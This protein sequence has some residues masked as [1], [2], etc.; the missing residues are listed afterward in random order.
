[1]DLQHGG[2]ERPECCKLNTSRGARGEGIYPRSGTFR[3]QTHGRGIRCVTFDRY[4]L[5]SLNK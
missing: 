3:L 4:A 5:F 2:P 1:M